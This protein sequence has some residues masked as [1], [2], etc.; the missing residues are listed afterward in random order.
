MVEAVPRVTK[1][2]L[3]SIVAEGGG[4]RGAYVLGV[5]EALYKYFGLKRVDLLTGSSASIGTLVCYCSGQLFGDSGD[6]TPAQKVWIEGVARS[7]FLSVKN[8]L[9]GKPLM[10]I[11]YLIDHLFK[12]EIPLD[13]E[14]VKSSRMRL[15]VPL[16][17]TATGKTEYFDNYSGVD[18]FTLLKACMAAPIINNRT[19]QIGNQHYVDGAFSDAFPIDVEGVRDSQKII[20]ITKKEY[21]NPK[22][23]RNNIF[24][25]FARGFGASSSLYETLVKKEADY[26]RR[27]KQIDCLGRNGDIVLMPSVQFSKLGNTKENLTTS[28]RSGYEDT[29][30]N[31]KLAKFIQA[32]HASE[33]S[34]F[35]FGS[36]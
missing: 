8:I 18:I 36:D 14:R 35:Y 26:T 21:R 22:D 3:V 34:A 17:N 28:I 33:K 25:L 13:V 11:E 32:L 6:I 1:S 10:D 23:M 5:M 19:I 29:I 15:I 2:P 12:K 31:E 30:K 24:P 7:E 9:R 4:L 16:T 20:I 27:R